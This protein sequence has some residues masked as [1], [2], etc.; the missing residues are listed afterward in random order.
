MTPKESAN[1][2]AVERAAFEKWAFDNWQNSYPP[3]AAWDGWKARAGL[4]SG[5][6][7]IPAG[8]KAWSGGDSAPADWDGGDVMLEGGEIIPGSVADIW[9][10]DNPDYIPV[11]AYTP[12]APTP[13]ICVNDD[14]RSRLDQVGPITPVGEPAVLSRR[15]GA[16]APIEGGEAVRDATVVEQADAV[17]FLETAFRNVDLPTLSADDSEDIRDGLQGF[18]D[19][20]VNAAIAALKPSDGLQ[21]DM[22]EARGLDA[23]D[24]E[25]LALIMLGELHA[26][27]PEAAR[28]MSMSDLSDDQAQ[29]ATNAVMR[30]LPAFRATPS[31]SAVPWD[32]LIAAF[33]PVLRDAFPDAHAVT[34]MQ[35]GEALAHEVKKRLHWF[36]AL[37]SVPGDGR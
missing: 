13:E 5:E 17:S 6:E 20:R 29:R 32:G 2:E 28:P 30:I 19:Q 37:A 12:K 14:L 31:A 4:L 10:H 11:V 7:T 25:R 21:T 15:I 16:P 34:R 1:R 26:H 33:G 27:L 3:A 35:V 23:N 18:V 24:I 36:A 8:M 9:Q 22:V